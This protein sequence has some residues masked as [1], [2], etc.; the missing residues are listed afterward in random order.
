MNLMI[1]QLRENRGLTQEKVADV[2]MC[3]QSLFPNTNAACVLCRWRLPSDWQ[4]I[5]VSVWIIWQ[6]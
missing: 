4:S 6:A 3:D 2:L 5:T 1:R